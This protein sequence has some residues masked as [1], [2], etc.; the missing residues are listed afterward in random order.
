[1]LTVKS[2]LNVFFFED[3]LDTSI[4]IEDAHRTPD[5]YIFLLD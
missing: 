1:M 2:L 5:R 3:Q 4:D